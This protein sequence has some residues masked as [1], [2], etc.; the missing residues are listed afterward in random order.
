MRTADL[1]EGPRGRSD[2]VVVVVLQG[3]VARFQVFDVAD[4]FGKRAAAEGEDGIGEF[5]DAAVG[6]ARRDQDGDGITEGPGNGGGL[7]F[8]PRSFAV[9]RALMLY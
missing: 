9:R 1:K 4:V 2:Y 8:D 3:R 5:G 7:S 6:E